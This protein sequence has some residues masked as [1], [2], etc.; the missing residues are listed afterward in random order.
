LIALL[1]ALAASLFLLAP[2]TPS[3]EETAASE[4]LKS[5][6]A[7]TGLNYSTSASGLS[8]T[9]V[10]DNADKRKQTVY[11]AVKPGKLETMA[12]SLYTTVWS[13][14]D[15]PGE[16][17]MRSVLAKSKKL[18]AYYLF[19]DTK[20]T[21]A[22]RFSAHFDAMDLKS[23]S[24]SGEALVTTL[25]DM[26]YFVNQVGEETDKELNGTKDNR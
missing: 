22:I 25:K 16:A 18:G 7:A 5:A 15:A 21:W 11:V 20:G 1:P 13:G 17:L 6:L 24:A 9:V 14:Q 3:P 23:T 19:K 26:L 12:H 10:F 2:Q 4:R 8:Y